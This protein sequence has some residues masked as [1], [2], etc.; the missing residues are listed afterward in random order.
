MVHGHDMT[1]VI[2]VTHAASMRRHRSQAA[3]QTQVASPQP[4]AKSKFDLGW[5]TVEKEFCP[6]LLKHHQT[7]IHSCGLQ[8][9]A[10]VL[11]PCSQQSAQRIPFNLKLCL[12]GYQNKPERR[13]PVA[14]V[15]FLRTNQPLISHAC[16]MPH[17]KN[18]SVVLVKFWSYKFNQIVVT[19]IEHPGFH[20]FD[21]MQLCCYVQLCVWFKYPLV[22]LA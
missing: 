21:I 19:A 8:L 5:K 10:Y 1:W 3:N 22:P 13:A 17:A 7:R 14:A 12:W 9:E 4:Q 15:C 11:L 2:W 6:Q 16:C 20:L 18:I